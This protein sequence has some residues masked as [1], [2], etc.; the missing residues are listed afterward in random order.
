MKPGMR[1]RLLSGNWYGPTNALTSRSV[2][3]SSRTSE[4]GARSSA[5]VVNRRSR[6]PRVANPR[7]GDAQGL[8]QRA[9]IGHRGH[10]VGVTGPARNDVDVQVFAHAAA[11][12]TPEV[13]PDVHPFGPVGLFER[14]HR[15]GDRR[16]QL[17]RLRLVEI[18]QLGNLAI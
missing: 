4:S 8:G 17:R 12:R 1:R 14:P 13:E 9:R 16:P 18:L 3:S 2:G 11:G 5:T 15:A 6:W 10:E 7:C